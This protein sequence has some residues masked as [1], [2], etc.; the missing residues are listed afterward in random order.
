MD[1]LREIESRASARL[2]GKIKAI[3]RMDGLKITFDDG[4]WLLFRKSGTENVVRIYAESSS[5][6]R[7]YALLGVGRSLI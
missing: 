4:A 3:N 5:S 1:V 2:G 6:E 7:T